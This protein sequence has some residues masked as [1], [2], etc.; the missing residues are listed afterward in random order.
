MVTIRERLKR[1]TIREFIERRKFTVGVVSFPIALPGFGMA[2]WGGKYGPWTTVNSIGLG[3]LLLSGL[4]FLACIG[5]IR[6]PRCRRSIGLTTV[7]L[8]R[9]KPQ[10][11]CCVHCGLSFREPMDRYPG[12]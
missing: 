12:E 10:P 9:D 2:A 11:D 5:A 7:S 1:P 4:V 6:C 8:D 3:A